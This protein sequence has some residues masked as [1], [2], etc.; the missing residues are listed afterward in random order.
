MIKICIA[1]ATGRMGSTLIKELDSRSFQIVGAVISPEDRNIGKSLKEAGICDSDVKLMGPTN[2]DEAVKDAEVYIT[3]TTP[4]AEVSNLPAVAE[5]GKRIVS[6]TTGFTDEQMKK[7][8]GAVLGKVPAVFSPNFSL[9][10]NILFKLIQTLNLFPP[11]YDFSI[12][13]IHHTGKKDAPS[14]TAK[15]LSG[16]VSSLRGYSEL[17]Y[18]REGFSPRMSE[19][20][21]VSSLRIGGVPGIHDLLIA[22]QHEMMRIEHITL[23]RSVFALGAQYVAKWIC[24]QI[25]PKIYTMDD[26]L[27]QS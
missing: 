14:G 20:L 12:I 5:R 27:A 4:D 18:G 15:K 3:F 6:G 19:E 21:E 7:I 17:V 9:G 11:E 10:I 16:I 22:G 26:V 2:L 23:S 1:G 24:K 13:E 25:E 8:R